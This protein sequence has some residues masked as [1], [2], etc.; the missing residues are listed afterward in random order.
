MLL[1]AATVLVATAAVVLRAPGALVLPLLLI[2]RPR[3]GAVT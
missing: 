2:S 3:C 1:I